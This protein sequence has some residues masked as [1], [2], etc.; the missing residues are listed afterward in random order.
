VRE[1]SK[2]VLVR[3]RKGN[4]VADQTVT[5]GSMNAHEAVIT[6]GLTDG[7]VIERNRAA[8]ARSPR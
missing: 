7:A 4:D 8:T 3:V 6:S 5:V 1:R 2:Q